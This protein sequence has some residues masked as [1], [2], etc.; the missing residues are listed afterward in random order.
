VAY[1]GALQT[2]QGGLLPT[3]GVASPNVT[4]ECVHARVAPCREVSVAG[5]LISVRR[6][7]VAVSYRLIAV[8]GCLIGV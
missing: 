2:V 8:R 1:A 3:V 4:G 6:Q 5:R 7:L